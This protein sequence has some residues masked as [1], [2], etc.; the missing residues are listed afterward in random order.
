MTSKHDLEFYDDING[1]KC[2]SCVKAGIDNECS[3]TLTEMTLA[4]LG[5]A[6]IDYGFEFGL[7][8]ENSLGWLNE[9]LLS[10]GMAAIFTVLLSSTLRYLNYHYGERVETEDERRRNRDHCYLAFV[11]SQLLSGFCAFG[12]SMLF[13]YGVHESLDNLE[14]NSAIGLSIVA[15][16]G[17]VAGKT[18]S[19]LALFKG[20]VKILECAKKQ[21]ASGELSRLEQQIDDDFTYG[22]YNK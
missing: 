10:S 8:G 16:V 12:I 22:T 21:L 1:H 19:R 2:T 4:L 9:A 17:I 15:P 7:Q 5:C 3:T 20:A 6:A 18:I 13:D 11:L 14:N